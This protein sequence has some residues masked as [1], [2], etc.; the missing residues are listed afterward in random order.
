MD[1]HVRLPVSLLVSSL[2]FASAHALP[3]AE[4]TKTQV[5][6]PSQYNRIWERL[7]VV[8]PGVKHLIVQLGVQSIIAYCPICLLIY[9]LRDPDRIPPPRLP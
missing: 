9:V 6:S 4:R 5:C 7:E 1:A 8:P 2:L 3:S